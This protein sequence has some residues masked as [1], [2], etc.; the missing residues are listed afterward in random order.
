MRRALTTVTTVVVLWVLAVSAASAH[1]LLTAADPAPNA[2][3]AV[4][5]ASVTLTFTEPPDARLS[6]VRVLDSAGVSHSEGDATGVAGSPK[7]LRVAV[8]TLADGVYTVAWRTVSAADGHIADGAYAFSVARTA[9]PAVP[10][11]SAPVPA[12]RAAGAS[13]GVVMSRWLLYLGLLGLL[14]AAFLG[15]VVRRGSAPKVPLGLAIGELAVAL[16]GSVSL[17]SFQ[18]ADAGASLGDVVGSSLGRDAAMRLTPLVVASGLLGAA[19]DAPERIRRLL[20]AAA[21]SMAAVALLAEALLSHAT[22]QAFAPLA[23]AIQFLHLTFVGLWL[24]GLMALLSQVRGPAT[25]EKREL[26]RRFAA[27]AAFGLAFVALTGLLRSI[28]DIAT[29][30][31]LIA[32]DFGRLVLLKVGLLVPIAGLGAVNHFYSV[33]RAGRVLSPLRRVGSTELALGTVALLA[34]SLLVTIAP[35][36]EVSAAGGA[37]SGSPAA[38]A[39][40]VPLSVVGSDYGT[41]V[42]LRLTVSPGAVG[43]N[44]FQ[45]RVTDFDTGAPVEVTA[46]RLSFKMPARPDVGSSTL[47]LRGRSD[48]TFVGTGSNLSIAGLWRLSALVTEPTA[49][50]EVDL[51]VSVGVSPARV[52]VNTVPGSPT[53]YTVHL[54]GGNTVT[55]YLDP[56]TPGPNLLHATW[57]TAEGGEMPVSNVV[58]AVESASGS[59]ALRPE[60]FDAGHEAASVQVASLPMTFGIRATGPD[61]ASYQIEL[62]I[63]SKQ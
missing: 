21:G 7:S 8:G 13:M 47:S 49:A 29:L 31:A 10:T 6:S 28:A 51:N 33:P 1:A 45:V 60:I 11:A 4:A 24:G 63:G 52:D 42:R 25:P 58:M 9:P 57:F 5:P 39:S 35:P 40:S 22:S 59:T 37:S 19:T 54:G 36:T 23:V 43:S 61:G 55:I 50:V 20:L 62:E 46:V 12:G 38:S 48:G 32:T 53:L 16:V 18:I 34:A 30:D 15:A 2:V 27:L 17:V 41:T 3:L 26:A 14:G 44:E 56:G